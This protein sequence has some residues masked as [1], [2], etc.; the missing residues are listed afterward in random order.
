VIFLRERV[1]DSSLL[2]P[3]MR[4]FEILLP[5]LVSICLSF[6]LML[7]GSRRDNLRTS[8]SD[9]GGGLE[10]PPTVLCGSGFFYSNPLRPTRGL[11][12]R[13]IRRNGKQTKRNV[14]LLPSFS[15]ITGLVACMGSFPFF[16][17]L[18]PP[19]KED[20]LVGDGAD[21]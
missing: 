12:S 17:F 8:S 1:P 7:Q 4:A 16:F 3:Q 6:C 19:S 14:K 10:Y 15:L 13:S 2:T 21:E 11:D 18:P 20:L 9:E 5:A